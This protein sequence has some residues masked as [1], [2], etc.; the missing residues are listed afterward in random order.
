[1]NLLTSLI[2]AIAVCLDSFAI[3]I[4]IGI[5]AKKVKI[6]QAIKA[7]VILAAIQ[8]VMVIIGWFIVT[9]TK[10]AISSIDHWIGFGILT[11]VGG[12]MVYEGLKK[13]K[14]RKVFDPFRLSVLVTLAIAS[15]IDALAVGVSL[16]IINANIFIT[17]TTVTV[18]TFVMAFLGIF[19]GE[20]KG[21]LLGDRME[22]VGGVTLI[23]IGISFLVINW[24]F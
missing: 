2:V 17:A 14:D 12:R 6:R 3:A 13:K 5:A 15:S 22:I 11:I 10:S 4:T 8:G 16:T 23:L 21:K 9:Q 18:L 19:I 1:M 20:R 7:A 24:Y